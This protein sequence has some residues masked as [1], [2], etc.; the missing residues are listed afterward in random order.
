MKKI[1]LAVLLSVIVAEISAQ[2]VNNFRREHPVISP[3]IGDSTITFRLRAPEAQKVGLFAAFLNNNVDMVRNENGVWEF[4]TALPSPELYL[5]KFIVDGIQVCDPNN[6][7]QQRDGVNYYS[8]VIIPGERTENYWESKSK[9]GTIHQIWYESPTLGITRRMYVYT[10]YGYESGNDSYPVLYLFHGAGG[11]EDAWTNMGRTRQI[12]DNLIEKGEAVPMIVVMPNGNPNQA[13][14][15]PLR[16]PT[17]RDFNPRDPKN[18]DA[19]AHSVAKDI[20]PFVESHFRCKSEKQYR[21]VAGLSMGGGHTIAVSGLYPELFDYICPLSNGIR[22]DQTTLERLDNLKSAGYKLYWL[23]C[24]S[25]D[26]LIQ[27]AN[28]LDSTL[29]AKQ[30]PHTYFKNDGGHTW[31]NWRLY[32]NTFAKLLFR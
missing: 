11:D 18:A 25:D 17:N 28:A 13:A 26:F 22:A 6:A 27:R 5:Y 29:T 4:T 19:Y 10:P 32:L 12:M 9:H 14:A 31:N 8:M 21:A 20:I 1:F 16:I 23:G 24:G 2:E 15:A 30:M 3:E 7:F